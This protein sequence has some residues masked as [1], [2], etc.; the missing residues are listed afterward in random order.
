MTTKFFTQIEF[1][2][3]VESRV[4]KTPDATYM[5]TILDLC[6]EYDIEIKSIGKLISPK[7]KSIIN[8]EAVSL[9]FFKEDNSSTLSI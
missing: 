7:I 4:R 1:S 8:E 3:L 5:D 2:S 9:N 6:E